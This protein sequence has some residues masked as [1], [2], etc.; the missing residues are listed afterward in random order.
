MTPTP[1][2]HPTLLC[3]QTAVYAVN[4]I[5]TFPDLVLDVAG[6]H[7][8]RIS[9]AD[10]T[11]L[12]VTTPVETEVGNP[13]ALYLSTQPGP[14]L[15]STQFFVLPAVS[16]LDRGGNLVPGV[17]LTITASLLRNSDGATLSG[18]TDVATVGGVAQFNDLSIAGLGNGFTL[19][20][21][22]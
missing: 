2:L 16:V 5:A 15:D 1:H 10:G 21:S 7:Q 6:V 9:A 14:A 18:T 8:I 19:R 3:L 4:G 17:T 12:G 13:S 11:G 20:F 22:S